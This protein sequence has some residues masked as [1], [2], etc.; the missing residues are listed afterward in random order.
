M[1]VMS[2]TPLG[3]PLAPAPYPPGWWVPDLAEAGVRR[4]GTVFAA[5]IVTWAS[6]AIMLLG[7]ASMLVFLLW[8]GEPI[9]DSFDWSRGW[10]ITLLAVAAVWSVAACL[11]ARWA[12]AGH[13]WA[14]LLLAASSAV[15][16]VASAALFWLGLPIVSLF[17]AVAVLVLLFIGGAN[18]WY[19]NQRKTP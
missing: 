9:L 12:L 18:E 11:L 19:R 7:T 5:A 14:R 3:E 17:G 13:N 2:E 10:V 8:L 1:P 15:T 16:V 6:S 4:P